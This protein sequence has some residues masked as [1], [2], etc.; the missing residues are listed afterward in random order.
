MAYI[1]RLAGSPLRIPTFSGSI[2]PHKNEAIFSQS[3]YEVKDDLKR[4]SE[5]TVGIWISRSQRGPP[6]DSVRSTVA[7]IAA[8]LYKMET[9]VP[10]DKMMRKLFRISHAKEENVTNYAIRLETILL[11]CEGIIPL[12]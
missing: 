7:A 10:L 9:V 6:A 3:I 2:P 12:W 11:I 5:S 8:I 1:H 4:F